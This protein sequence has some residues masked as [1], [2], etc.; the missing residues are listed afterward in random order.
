VNRSLDDLAREVAELEKLAPADRLQAAQ[1]L[2]Q[3]AMALAE[4]R[5]Q[6]A[7]A[8]AGALGAGSAARPYVLPG[9]YVPAGFDPKKF[10]VTGF[11]PEARAKARAHYDDAELVR[12]DANGVYPSGLAD[13]TLADDYFIIYHYNSPSRARRPDDLPRGV[14]H[15]PNCKFYVWVSAAGVRPYPLDGWE[16]KEPLLGEPRCTVKEVWKQAIAKGAPADNA[17]A[18]VSYYDWD[19]AARWYLTIGDEYSDSRGDS[20]Q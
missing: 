4:R 3:E 14:K 9:T 7:M 16:C 10:D 19:G 15:E 6:E 18:Q 17:V 12:I 1:K 5:T 20:C 11:L 13:L 8:T 2:S